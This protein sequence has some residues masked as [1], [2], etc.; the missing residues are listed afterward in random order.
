MKSETICIIP[1][2]HT[3]IETTGDVKPCC[4]YNTPV[5]NT[6]VDTLENIWNSFEYQKIRQT[7]LDNKVPDGC[8]QCFQKEKLGGIS[9][10]L[11][12][13]NDRKNLFNLIKDSSPMFEIRYLDI[14]FSNV[15]NYKCRMCGPASSHRINAE[16]RLNGRPHYIKNIIEINKQNSL[17]S[18]YKNIN[19]IDEVYFCGGEPLLLE[20]HYEFLEKLI[21]ANNLNVNLRYSTNLSKLNFKNLNVLN[22]WKKF[23]TVN[24]HVS[25]DNI[26]NKLSYCRHGADWNNTINNLK[27]VKEFKNI[28]LYT[29]TTV[30]IFNILDLP[31]IINELVTNLKL[32][33]I[34]N[35]ILGNILDTPEFYSIQSLHPS[36]KLIAEKQITDFI[37]NNN[38]SNELK[39][40]LDYIIKFM[41]KEN[42]FD[43]NKLD[44][45]K[46]TTFLD[47]VRKEN[48]LEA[49]PE[50]ALQYNT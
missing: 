23:N 1:W 33:D 47:S 48:F 46:E 25:L 39:N 49:Y 11:R 13:N 8:S 34:N 21:Q 38:L 15:C 50:L 40:S 17:N 18:I 37:L 35:I 28:N 9:K 20:Q 41:Y 22:Y 4:L 3:H 12:E 45:V 2:I 14:R 44:F 27:L 26:E 36:L 5:G 29:S 6:N 42:L 30:S 31:N 43:K 19:F 10:R 32:I 7:M 16:N 24:L